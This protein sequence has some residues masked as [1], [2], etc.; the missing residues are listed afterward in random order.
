MSKFQMLG[1]QMQ[2]LFP[3]DVMTRVHAG[4]IRMIEICY[5]T[6]TLFT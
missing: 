4:G 5:L 6:G 3:F 2:F 1:A